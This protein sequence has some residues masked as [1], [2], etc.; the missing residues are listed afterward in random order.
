MKESIV[1]E[2]S[3]LFCLSFAFLVHAKEMTPL[4]KENRKPAQKL[5]VRK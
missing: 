5:S 2:K 3:V 4:R 1:T